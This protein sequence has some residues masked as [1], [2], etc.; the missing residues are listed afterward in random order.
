MKRHGRWTTSA[1]VRVTAIHQ[2]KSG[3][4]H[5]H[6]KEFIM[7]ARIIL[8]VF[9]VLLQA[10]KSGKIGVIFND[11]LNK[12]IRHNS[13]PQNYFLTLIC[14][15]VFEFCSELSPLSSSNVNTQIQD[16]DFTT[17]NRLLIQLCKID[18]NTCCR[19]HRNY[20]LRG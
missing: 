15:I 7:A 6:H 18:I 10:E 3:Y 20:N 5:T 14:W 9:L 11:K 16:F 8:V 1:N 13:T 17:I 12:L 2:F 4:N 19:R